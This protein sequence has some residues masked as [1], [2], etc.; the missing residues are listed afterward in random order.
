MYRLAVAKGRVKRLTRARWIACSAGCAS[1]LHSA[2][3]QVN[4]ACLHKPWRQLKLSG[5]GLTA[6]ADQLRW[7]KSFFH[8]PTKCFKIIS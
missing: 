7:N 1:A 4:A 6:H 2:T 3:V 8:V 5:A